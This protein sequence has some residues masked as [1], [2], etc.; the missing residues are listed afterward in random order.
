VFFSLSKILDVLF[1]PLTW[2]LLLCLYAFGQKNRGNAGWYALLAALVLGTFSLEPVS[3]RL[4]RWTEV[5]APRTVRDGVTYDAIILLG[6]L[7]E[8]RTTAS[9]HVPAYNDGVERL[10]TTYDLLRT[11]RARKA[12]L[13]GGADD[14]QDPVVEADLLAK[15][16]EAWG[17]AADRLILEGKSRNTRENAEESTR[18]AKEQRLTTLLLVT[19][20][21]HMP[22]ALAA[23]RATGIEPDTLPVDFRSFDPA[24]S[25]E[26]WLPRAQALAES[27]AALRELA[28]RAIYAA[29]GFGRWTRP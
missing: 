6:G 27:T 10:L 24:G 20:A 4:M 1:S 16:L 11:G 19:S 21:A 25:P 22:R 5:G 18:L 28:G 15:Q 17:I 12:I 13:S 2:S 3:N 8:H 9:T 29:A 14:D 7:V 23:F 26:K